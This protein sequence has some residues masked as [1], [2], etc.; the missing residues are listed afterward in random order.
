MRL[1]LF[2]RFIIFALLFGVLNAAA[3][4]AEPMPKAV[5]AVLDYAR[6]LQASDAAKDIR[7]QVKLYGDSFRDVVQ[8]EEDRLRGIEAELK[9]QR[10]VL[11]PDAYEEMRQDFK[12][13]VI[14]AQ[15]QGQN[16]KRDLEKAL[17]FATTQLQKAVIPIVKK[18]TE[19]K[20]YTIVVDNSQV[21]FADGGLD[22]TEEVLDR[23]NQT[24]R[25][26]AVPK[27]Q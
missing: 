10:S 21:L 15:R 12:S 9:R 25:T 2:L 7:R 26:V 1:S 5:I 3:T 13:Q 27:P 4:G 18:L 17:K 24:L 8:A 16:F 23:L 14:T 19:E 22:I 11:S 6:I 20:G